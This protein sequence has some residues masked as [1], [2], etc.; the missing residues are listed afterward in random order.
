MRIPL[1]TLPVCFPCNVASRLTSRHHWIMVM[2]VID[3][4]IPIR[5]CSNLLI[6]LAVPTNIRKAPKAPV[7]G[8][9]LGSTIWNGCLVILLF[10]KELFYELRFVCWKHSVPF[11]W[12]GN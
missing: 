4:P 10:H 8:Q 11:Y 6:I 1:S 5:Y 7:T 9:G 12:P 2:S 3:A